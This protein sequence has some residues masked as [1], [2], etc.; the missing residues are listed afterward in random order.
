M[1][2]KCVAMTIVVAGLFVC[3]AAAQQ[4]VRYYEQGGITYRETRTK[5]Q[6]PTREVEYKDVP[7]QYYRENYQTNF[8]TY[9]RAVYQPTTQYRWEPRWH[10]WWNV[11]RGPHVA[12]HLRPQ[13]VWQPSLQT[14]QVPVTTRTVVPE[15]TTVRMAVPK[16]AMKD[17]EIVT[18]TAVGPAAGT[19]Q[20]AQTN[21][22][23]PVLA[24]NVPAQPAY[25]YA[26]AP[27]VY[28]PTYPVIATA[29]NW[30]YGGVAR[31]EGDPPRW[32]YSYR[33]EGAWQASNG[34][35]L[36]R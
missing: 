27:P 5:T 3:D 24:W 15:T 1:T 9:Q 19:R 7:Q 35:P 12:Y 2:M 17:D 26:W 28:S 16:L 21:N 31:L 4:H 30:G 8:Q 25:G 29:P 33:S 13:T 22:A 34:A 36:T 11:F 14:Y 23:Q 32:G 18:R 6:I 10:E 20:L